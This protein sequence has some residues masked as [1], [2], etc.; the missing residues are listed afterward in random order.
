MR[1]PPLDGATVVRLH[2]LGSFPDALARLLAG[3]KRS[4]RSR[5]RDRFFLLAGHWLGGDARRRA[6]RLHERLV[7]LARRSSARLLRIDVSTV[8]GA[9]TAG[10]LVSGWAVPHQTTV[11]RAL[12]EARPTFV[13]RLSEMQS[14]PSEKLGDGNTNAA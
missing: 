6:G 9:L 8:D 1:A 7:E 2:N 11:Y 3:A 5:E 13:H 4:E 10:L 14:H 12:V